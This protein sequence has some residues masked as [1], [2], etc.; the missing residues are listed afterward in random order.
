MADRLL[1][2]PGTGFIAGGLRAGRPLGMNNSI[3]CWQQ[4][5]FHPLGPTLGATE[6]AMSVPPDLSYARAQGRPIA[7]RR[8]SRKTL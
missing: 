5:A 4:Q 3:L 7:C 6:S 2:Y 8:P 1:D